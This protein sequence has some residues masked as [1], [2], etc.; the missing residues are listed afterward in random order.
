MKTVKI[1]LG[2]VTID[3]SAEEALKA[4]IA[5]LT[6]ELETTKFELATAQKWIADYQAIA[7]SSK[8]QLAD[9]TTASTKY[10]DKTT[11]MLK[12][13]RQSEQS[14]CETVAELI[15]DLIAYRGEKDKAVNELK[16][17]I[18]S[19]TSQLS[20]SREDAFQAIA[21]LES[22][23][24]EA[25]RY[26]LDAKNANAIYERE[27][28]LHAEAR[29]ALQDSR[30]GWNQNSAFARLLR[31]SLLLHNQTLR[32]RRWRGNRRRRSSTK[33]KLMICASRI[34]CYMTRWLLFRDRG[35]VSVD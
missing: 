9:L 12:K 7:K 32:P 31:P 18:D 4:N 5:L 24:S 13:L 21:R 3:T 6:A 22:L 27:L 35:Q 19:L 20:G 34:K 1:Q 11:A 17:M 30:P 29:A 8:E 15:N 23:T 14:Q 10:K 26:Q 28:V 25:R 2:D 16:S 33:S